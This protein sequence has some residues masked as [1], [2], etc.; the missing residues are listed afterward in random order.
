ME[1]QQTAPASVTDEHTGERRP[2]P[3]VPLDRDPARLIRR[4][5]VNRFIEFGRFWPRPFNQ[6]GCSFRSSYYAKPWAFVMDTARWLR[7]FWQRGWYGWAGSDTWELEHTLATRLPPMLRHLNHYKQGTPMDFFPPNSQPWEPGYVW[8][9]PNDPVAVAAEQHMSATAA[10][11]FTDWL[12]DTARAFEDY[13]WL[14]QHHALDRW[15][16]DEW[17]DACRAADKA[18]DGWGWDAYPDPLEMAGVTEE[19][20]QE[21]IDEWN[22]AYVD[23]KKR[24]ATLILHFDDLWD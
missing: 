14:T 12:E 19:Q 22:A 20:K 2:P 24:M 11:R 13:V 16:T 3:L 17:H 7:A 5:P 21:A 15:Y 9:D 6:E 4:R 23:A 1:Q 18:H 8:P 10:E